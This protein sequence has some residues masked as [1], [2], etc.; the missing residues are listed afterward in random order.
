MAEQRKCKKLASVLVEH[1]EHFAAMSNE[2]C[3]WAIENPQE[4]VA[5]FVSAVKRRDTMVAKKLLKLVGT[6]SV[7]AIESFKAADYFKVDTSAKAPVKIAWLGENFKK[8][9]LG[10]VENASEAADL[11]VHKLLTAARD[12]P[13][14]DEPGIIPE[15]GGRHETMLGQ[16]YSLL[17]KQGKGQAG[18]LLVNGRANIAYIRDEEGIF[19]AVN[20]LWGACVDGWHVEACSVEDPNGWNGGN[21][22]VSR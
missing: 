13:E 6:V 4:A 14:D 21:Q 12:L 17:Q 11:N 8:H 9:F 20:A 1:Q 22:V 19:W 5:L 18:T 16:L 15:L 2:D 10:K 7:P 3:Q